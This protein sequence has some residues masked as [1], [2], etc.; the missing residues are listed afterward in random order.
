MFGIRFKITGDGRQWA[1]GWGIDEAKLATSWLT[2]AKLDDVCREAHYIMHFIFLNHWRFWS[3]SRH[4]EIPRPGN[5]PQQWKAGSLT[6]WA[7]R[8]LLK[9]F[10]IKVLLFFFWK[11]DIFSDQP[12]SGC[13]VWH[14]KWRFILCSVP[15]CQLQK[16]GYVLILVQWKNQMHFTELS[17]VLWIYHKSLQD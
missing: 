6:C 10:I 16:E 17:L 11:R 1:G 5:E 4:A 13:W 3:C 2:W 8:G 7:I 12:V 14:I 15:I 9:F